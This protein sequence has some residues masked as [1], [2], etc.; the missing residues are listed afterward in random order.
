MHR[1]V[2]WLTVLT[3]AAG[4][5][6]IARTERLPSPSPYDAL[7]GGPEREEPDGSGM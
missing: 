4:C 6:Y 3:L 7:P 1:I 2:I 5:A